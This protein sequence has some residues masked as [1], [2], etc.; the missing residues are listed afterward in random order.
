MI[1]KRSKAS[2]APSPLTSYLASV[3]SATSATAIASLVAVHQPMPSPLT[4]YL[5]LDAVVRVG[6][7]VAAGAAMLLLNTS[8]TRTP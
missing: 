2:T 1:S 7:V 8:I 6:V 3:D 4:S 5:E